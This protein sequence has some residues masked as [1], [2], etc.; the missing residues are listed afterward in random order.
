MG[1]EQ[2]KTNSAV[3]ATMLALGAAAMIGGSA[4]LVA[5]AR[6]EIRDFSQE[7]QGFANLTA[8]H[9]LNA[10]QHKRLDSAK[11]PISKAKT[12]VVAMLQRDPSSASPAAP[13]PAASVDPAA[14]GSTVPADSAAPADSAVPADSAAPTT[15]GSAPGAK[16][17]APEVPEKPEDKK[18][19]AKGDKGS[20]PAPKV[21]TGTP[22]P[23]GTH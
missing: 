17:D 1:T 11:L 5:L 20:E 18:T 19:D 3:I 23:S 12:D 4:A 10:E 21:P 15:S 7:S 22:A 16:G 6:G 13:E 9:D 2:D 14:S 8:V